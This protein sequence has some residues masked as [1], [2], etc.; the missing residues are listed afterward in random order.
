MVR[1]DLKEK[2]A[3]GDIDLGAILAKQ[4]ASFNQNP[5][6]SWSE[7]KSNLKKLGKAIEEHAAEFQKA[8][9]E[10]FGNRAY[11]ETTIAELMII[12]GGISHALKNTKHWMRSRRAP[13]AIQYLSLIHI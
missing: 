7:R 6:P 5:N 2:D 10:D 3:L 12:Q 1:I 11:E 13:T 4:K 8:I 9:S